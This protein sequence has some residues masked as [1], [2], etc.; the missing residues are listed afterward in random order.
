M[1]NIKICICQYAKC[2]INTLISDNNCHIQILGEKYQ[3]VYM[4]I[5]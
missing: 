1:R 2:P 4:T 5:C 3:N